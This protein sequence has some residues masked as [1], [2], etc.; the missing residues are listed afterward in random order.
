MITK[1][2]YMIDGVRRTV[3]KAPTKVGTSSLECWVFLEKPEVSIFVW[4][5]SYENRHILRENHSNSRLL[6]IT[7]VT[8]SHVAADLL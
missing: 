5:T 7:K 6:A 8:D 1:H 4:A 2:R 3:W